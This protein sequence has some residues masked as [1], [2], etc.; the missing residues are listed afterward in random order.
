[1]ITHR[2]S[3]QTPEPPVRF[4]KIIAL[5]FL[6]I[7]V[8]LLALVVFVTSKKADIVIVAKADPKNI[9]LSIA[10]NKDGQGVEAIKGNVSAVPF[11]WAQTFSP[12]GNKKVDA[13]VKGEVV[14]YNK[15]NVP[16]PLVKT[17]R[18]LTAT[19]VLF[20]LSAGTVVPANGQVTVPVYA[21]VPGV[22][23]EIAPSQFTIPGL[24][25][26]KQQLVYAE[27]TVAMI[28]GSRSV[29][30]LSA[31]DIK[32]AEDAYKQK[33]VEAYLAANPAGSEAR[34]V[35]V[36]EQVLSVN[37]K[38]GEEVGEFVVS[39]SSTMAVVSYGASDLLALVNKKATSKI[40]TTAEKLLSVARAPEVTLARYALADG[41]ADLA[42]SQTVMVTLDA[43]VEKLLPENFFGKGKDAI[44]RYILGL[45][46]VAGVDVQFSPSWIFTAPSVPDRIRV[47]VKNVQ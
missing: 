6:L 27:S 24:T 26:A 30:V 2:M 46:H 29:G 13:V 37:H 31:A 12:T 14:V 35:V 11:S 43:N 7:T 21:D 23:S 47:V 36:A 28:G 16:Q 41:T 38:P 4:Y 19:G 22:A 42:V 9:Q 32:N 10:V 34:A 33:V 1:M 3:T 44:Q 39:G 45:D 15:M 5:S 25:P 17:T 18:L 40:D 8:V 20:R